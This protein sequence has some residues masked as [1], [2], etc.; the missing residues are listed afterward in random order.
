MEEKKAQTVRPDSELLYAAFKA[1]PLGIAIEN[2]EG[3]PLFVNSALCLM[4][5]FTEQEMLGKHCV[6]FSP[7]EDAAKDWA[8][9]E[10]LRAGS[11]DHYQ[12]DKRFFRRD[13]S[14]VWGRLSISLLKGATSPM[15]V[16]MVE[17]ITEKKKAEETLRESEQ[18]FRL[19]ADTAPALILMSGTDK[20]CTYLNQPWLDFT[21][22]SLEEELKSG[23]AE[24]VH[25][26]DAKR[27]LDTYAQFFDRREK[28]SIE[29]RLRRHDGEYRWIL[30]IG[31][32]RFNQD[33]SFAG[34]I[35]IGV[36]VTER[37]Q[38]EEALRQS[39]EKFLKT[40]RGSPVAITLSRV[41]DRR[42]IEVNDT[43]ERL[44]GYRGE[45]VIGSTAS[46]IGL[47]VDPPQ[48]EELTKRLLS[49]RS[50]R[51]L[52]LRFHTKNGSV[53]TCSVS[54]EVIEVG[55]EPCILSVASDITQRKLAEESLRKSEE[56]FRLAA[57][58]GKMYAYEWDVATD[59]IVRS[60]DVP[61]VLGSTG[62][63]SLTSQQLL[64]RVHPDDQPA[65]NASV[66]ERTPEHPDV[67]ISYRV[68]RPDGSVVWVEKTA[69]AL[70][71]EGGRIVRTIGMVADITERKRIEETMRE[72]EERFRLAAQAGKMYAFEWDV[73]TDV[74]LRSSEY[75]NVLGATEP[76]T[77]T[78][79]QVMDKIHPDDRPKLAA[80]VARH[81]PENPMVDVTYRVLLPGKS[82]VWVKSSG[83]AFFD[84]KGRML[85]VIGMVSDITDQKLAEEALRASEE[86]L[87]LAQQVARIGTFER[88]TRT[89]VN[90]WTP[91][92]ESMYGLPPGGF[93]QTRTAFENLVHPDDRAGVINLVDRA[94][95]TGRPTKGEWRVIWP[96]GSVHW[97]AGRWQVLMDE[98]GEPSRVVGVNIDIT[99]RKQAEETLRESEEKFRSVFRD[100]GVGMVIVSPEGRFLAANKAFGDTLGY[101]EQEL[102]EKTV[103]SVTLS[104]DWPAFSKKLREALTEGR[105]FQWFEKRCLHK[106]GRIVYTASSASL[107][108]SRN[109]EP[110]YFVG[111]VL[112]V[113]MRKEAEQALADMARKLIAAQEQERT[114]IARELHDD[115]N[116][117]LAMLGIELAQAEQNHP[118]LP[119]DMLKC[120]HNLQEQTTQISADLQSLSHDLHS[121]QLEYLGVIAGMK[122]WCKEFG[123]RQG[124]QI[125]CRHDVRSTLP[126]DTGLCLFR[127]LQEALH[128]AAKH[129]GVK[130][131]NVELTEGSGGIHLVIRDLGKGFDLEAA[132]KGRGLG[133]TSMQER[134]RLVNGTI[135]IQS[136][137][138]GGTTIHVRIPVKSEH[139]SQRAA[140]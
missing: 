89:G 110:Q 130:R 21:G 36:D 70:F 127:V 17:D 44:T 4:L 83:R 8:L 29:Y 132:R 84:G 16:A 57:Q 111:E 56:R 101:T 2:L 46:D 112:D 116:Q 15:V 121:S 31:V 95:K 60:G 80:A 77:L 72:S 125:D 73:T 135:T 119:P 54:A 86:R 126:P 49:E 69:H 118:D 92:M 5:G 26:D 68:L 124:M 63:T 3:Q 87:R 105:G 81:S 99:E 74:L 98:S 47:W 138:M 137:P 37:K 115:I 82:P 52:E 25:P 109:G 102:Q 7:P 10:Q 96:D 51:D 78:H 97:I 1:C 53:L 75:V 48:R 136:K 28:Y 45:E 39:E 88:N 22:R 35:G 90:T 59:V 139:V 134:V 93:G 64:A 108:R 76:R 40:F 66:S 65:F 131:I 133:L 9:F 41:K 122:S 32:P 94:L 33:G 85:R 14:T 27:C 120:M 42:F 30:D 91:E 104:E 43:F 11:I 123:E 61:S 107:I 103:E 58:A 113:T 106:S 19:V 71:D 34:Y 128:N 24:R 55:K 140:G 62:E 50:L 20:G 18:R 79:Q 100:A 23:W 12:I 38:A 114:R 13:G 117:R 129:S 67:Q 6:E